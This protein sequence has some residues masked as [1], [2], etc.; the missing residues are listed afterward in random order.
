MKCEICQR[1]VSSDHYQ[2]HMEAH[3]SSDL[4]ELT[5]DDNGNVFTKAAAPEAPQAQHT[6]E[7]LAMGD[8]SVCPVCNPIN[9]RLLPKRKRE[10]ATFAEIKEWKAT[11][12][13]CHR[14]LSAAVQQRNELLDFAKDAVWALRTGDRI[15]QEACIEAGE[16]LIAKVEAAQ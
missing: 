13:E 3:R 1:R 4:P 6:M 5:G 8:A 12:E 15:A 16:T 7:C 2:A 9:D 10:H 14:K 11:I